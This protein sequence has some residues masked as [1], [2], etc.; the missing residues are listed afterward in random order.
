M[1]ERPLSLVA[2]LTPIV[3]LIALLAVNVVLFGDNALGGANQVG[4]LLAGS[5]AALIAMWHG[6]SWSK[7]F[8]GATASIASSLP[9]LLILLM[10]GALAGTWL[11]SGVVPAMVYYGLSILN[12]KIFLFA[13]ATVCA[14]VSMATGSSWSTVATVGI[15]LLGIG[16]ALGLPDGM[17]A[18]AIISGAYFGDKMSPLSDTTNLAPAMAGTNLVTHIRHMTW[19]TF[20]S[21]G[22]TLLIFL[23]IGLLRA[24]GEGPMEV[25]EL[26][27]A[28]SARFTIT[29]WLFVVPVAVVGL[30]MRRVPAVPALFLGSLL[31][32]LFAVLFQS[33]LFADVAGA[34]GAETGFWALAY[35]AVINAMTT[36]VAI[37]SGHPL[38]DELLKTGG[39]YGMMNTVWLIICAMTFGGIMEVSGMLQR[40]ASSI[41]S[42]AKSTGALIASTTGTCVVF[43]V[44]ASD[45]YLAI[46]VPGRMYANEYRE[47]GLAPENLSRVLE[48]SA[49]VTSALVPWNTCGA[50]HAGVLG[51]ATGTYLPFAFFNI[52][53]P[54]MTILFGAMGWKITPLKSSSTGEVSKR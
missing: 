36:D 14:I 4:L 48:D 12:P 24:P 50:Y 9:A 54:L 21:F 41:L 25:S 38:V 19:T 44:T 47:R 27:N 10:I 51:V 34:A 13:T 30:I 7:L 1:K 2:A 32:G 18:G 17:V 20:P 11:L 3:L 33:H 15:A 40:I 29:P 31:G 43:N 37:A 5:A 49:T 46:V 52:I 53:S 26:Q 16:R 39:M 45:Q 8:D 28:I 22:L 42:A 23:G 35:K 6:H